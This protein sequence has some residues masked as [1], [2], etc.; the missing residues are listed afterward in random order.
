MRILKVAD[1]PALQDRIKENIDVIAGD[2]WLWRGPFDKTG[3][4][5]LKWGRK[6]SVVSLAWI[7]REGG[8]DLRFQ[9]ETRCGH[10]AC[11]NPSHANLVKKAK[12]P[13]KGHGTCWLEKKGG[14][15]KKQAKQ[16]KK[17]TKKQRLAFKVRLKK[18]ATVLAKKAGRKKPLQKDMYAAYLKTPEWRAKRSVCLKETGGL[19]AFCDMK[20]KAVHHV[21][22]RRLGF[23]SVGD[24]VSVCNRHHTVLHGKASAS[25]GLDPDLCAFCGKG[26]DMLHQ[27]KYLKKIDGEEPSASVSACVNCDRV[28]GGDVSVS[29]NYCPPLGY[30]QISPKKDDIDKYHKGEEKLARKK[31]A[32]IRREEREVSR[33]L[34]AGRKRTAVEAAQKE[35]RAESRRLG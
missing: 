9:V 32:Q 34:A 26:A 23:E 3:R 4:P 7:A 25:T 6:R 21:V 16:I 2:H 22:Y 14:K 33:L 15:A 5:K 8:L 1:P 31:F 24:L 11:V 12:Q 28:A 17:Q 18:A 19:C 20:A 10:T 13:P 27:I 30:V 29:P 35:I